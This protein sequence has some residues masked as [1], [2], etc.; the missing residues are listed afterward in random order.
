M[1]LGDVADVARLVLAVVAAL[2]S[3]A[4]VLDDN[5][6]ILAHVYTCSTNDA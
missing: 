3:D 1:A 5:K 4:A 2:A 6:T